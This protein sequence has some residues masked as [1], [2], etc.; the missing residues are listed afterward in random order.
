MKKTCYEY[1]VCGGPQ[2]YVTV[3]PHGKTKRISYLAGFSSP[4][5]NR[6]NNS[7]ELHPYDQ[8]PEGRYQVGVASS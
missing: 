6:A 8:V 7:L 3:E 5:S 4:L 1:E 2:S